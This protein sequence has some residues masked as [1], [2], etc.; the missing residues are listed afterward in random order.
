VNAGAQNINNPPAASEIGVSWFALTAAEIAAHLGI[1]PQAIRKQLRGVPATGTRR[2]GGNDADTWE[3]AR[4]PGRLRKRLARLA[5]RKG[6]ASVEDMVK[7]GVTAWI[8]PVS[9]FEISDAC[10]TETNK[11]KQALLPSL[12]QQFVT[13]QADFE[14]D[15][16][17]DWGKVFGQK[18][19]VR[20]FRELIRRTVQRD[21]GRENWENLALYLPAKP[22]RKREADETEDQFPGLVSTINAGASPDE[23]WKKVFVTRAALIKAGVPSARADRQLR[24]FIRERKPGLAPS[25]GALLKTFGRRLERWQSNESF[26]MRHETNGAEDGELTSQIKALGWF[27]PAAEFFYLLTNRTKDSGSVPEAIRRTISL[28]NL[29]A[30]W[31]DTIKRRFL[32]KFRFLK[33][34]G[35]KNIIPACPD[36]LRET[37]LARERAGKPLVPASIAN[38]IHWKVSRNVIEQYRRPHEAGLNNLQCPGTMMMVRRHGCEPQFA[39]AGDIIE[40]DDGSINFPVC[41]PWTSPTGG[42]ITETP[43]SEKFGVIVGRFQWLRTIDVASRY[44]PGWV[45]VAR[46]RGGFRG[47]DV[48]T[49]LH[50]I[51]LQHGAWEQYRFERGVFKS[52]LV[53]HAI[54]LLGS[55]LHTVISPH[56]KPFIEGGFNQDWTKLSVHFPQ[57][58]IGRYRG[59]TEAAN[60]LVQSCRRG[61][62]DPRRYFPMLADALA[63]FA[64]ITAEENRTLVK[65]RN[66]GQWVPEDRWQR[67]TRE[68]ALRKVDEDKMFMF[69]PYAME[70][71]VK[72]MLVGGRV[73]IFEDMSVPFDFSAPWLPEFSGA[74][75]RLHFDPTAPK[76]LATP[77]LLQDWQ[78]HHA[79]EVL[80]PI[81]Q[82]NETTGY[83][84]LM[85]GW[86]DDAGADG[87]K[88][89][90]QAGVAMR[91]EVRTVMPGGRSGYSRSEM[92]ALES[93]GI[94]ERDG[95]GKEIVRGEKQI[96]SARLVQNLSADEARERK[97]NRRAELAAKM[98]DVEKFER[99]NQSLF[100]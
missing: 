16:V 89:K 81:N 65:S 7:S 20:H 52:D 10:L 75:M 34:A 69:S 77:V 33:K 11:R 94:I 74:K 54:E 95:G 51:T 50:G 83:I 70:W 28:P 40:A 78:D 71:T 67:E 86:G 84:R 23:I 46:S 41:I 30:G 39:R 90:Q 3:H 37:I 88:A 53:K 31:T 100:V 49:L 8:P 56:S 26:D 1:S 18:I 85:L 12:R 43:C 57:C 15:G 62:T 44:R 76:C 92:K 64:E 60:K 14:R 80:P 35:L 73:P 22:E 68:R 87:L 13:S 61:S 82:V 5:G 45:F 99:E 25:P 98:A 38:S 66:S 27:L 91:R 19:H 58:D 6:F 72:G 93:T 59:D 79:G 96:R 42:L 21:G 29:P 48:L 32:K 4:L 55:R 63:A 2:V 47:A 24:A 36:D 97:A 17:A 9:M